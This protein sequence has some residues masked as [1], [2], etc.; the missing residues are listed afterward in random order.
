MVE[1]YRE[2]RAAMPGEALDLSLSSYGDQPYLRA[3]CS[4][5]RPQTI[6]HHRVG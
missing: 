2:I 1:V 6:T 4:I 5:A 3:K